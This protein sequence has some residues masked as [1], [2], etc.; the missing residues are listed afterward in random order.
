MI[1]L[2]IPDNCEKDARDFIAWLKRERKIEPE[3]EIEDV[4]LIILDEK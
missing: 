2:I 1:I 3:T 4:K